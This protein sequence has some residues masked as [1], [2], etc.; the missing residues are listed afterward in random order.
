MCAIIRLMT[1][2]C[3]HY[4]LTSLPI[5]RTA[6]PEGTTTHLE[7][8]YN[9]EAAQLGYSF[10][11]EAKATSIS[12]LSPDT[13]SVNVYDPNRGPM[14]GRSVEVLEKE[15]INK[16][17]IEGNFGCVGALIGYRSRYFWRP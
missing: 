12:V 17:K 9:P 16:R 5:A 6:V 2:E 7:T 13:V 11:G 1:I 14:T 3:R 15:E 10:L 8:L 4:I